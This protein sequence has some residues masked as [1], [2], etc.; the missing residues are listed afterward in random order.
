M[1]ALGIP[2]VPPVYKIAA[3]SVLSASTAL[4]TPWEVE[5]GHFQVFRQIHISLSSYIIEGIKRAI[6]GK[7]V[8]R[9]MARKADSKHGRIPLKITVIGTVGA[10]AFNTKTLRPTG[11]VIRPTSRTMTNYSM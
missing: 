8:N 6:W 5:S 7:I 11:G 1:T 3:V 9:T 10:A 4:K 2:V